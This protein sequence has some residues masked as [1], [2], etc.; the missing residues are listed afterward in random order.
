MCVMFWDD[1]QTS[2]ESLPKAAKKQKT[3][4]EFD[5]LVGAGQIPPPFQTPDFKSAWERWLQFR[6]ELGKRITAS[7]ASHQLKLLT[8]K[9][10]NKAL[11]IESIDQSIRNGWIGLF[12]VQKGT[13]GRANTTPDYTTRDEIDKQNRERALEL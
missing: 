2:T 11:A 8:N 6:R 9:I 3:A 7:T 1:A 12:D 4:I 5:E 13:F 10:G